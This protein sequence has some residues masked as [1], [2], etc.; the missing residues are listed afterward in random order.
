MQQAVLFQ[1]RIKVVSFRRMC[2]R[3]QPPQ[4]QLSGDLAD[5]Q[6]RYAPCGH[7]CFGHFAPCKLSHLG[8]VFNAHRLCPILARSSHGN[9]A[10]A[11]A[12]IKHGVLVAHL[13]SCKHF[14]DQDFWHGNLDHIVAFLT[15]LRLVLRR[16][17]GRGCEG[18]IQPAGQ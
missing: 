16:S 15:D 1:M 5:G 12:Q 3:N 14:F 13:G 11:R 10:I 9:D 8:V 18:Q 2:L 7:A 4:C 17:G 6:S